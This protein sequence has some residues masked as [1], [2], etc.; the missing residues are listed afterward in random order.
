MSGPPYYY[1]QPPRI[2]EY[3]RFPTV[4]AAAPTNFWGQL[5][6]WPSTHP[7]F[8]YLSAHSYIYIYI[9]VCVFALAP[10]TNIYNLKYTYS[11][12]SN[13]ANHIKTKKVY[14]ALLY[15]LSENLLFY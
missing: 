4:G 9:C 10:K 1:A 11:S 14:A 13:D 2:E 8:P 7:L 6:S 5:D 15:Y 12:A 3:L